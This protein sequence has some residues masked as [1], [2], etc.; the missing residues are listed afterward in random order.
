VTATGTH[1]G[2]H[3]YSFGAAA[4]QASCGIVLDVCHTAMK[5]GDTSCKEASIVVARVNSTFFQIQ[6]SLVMGGALSSR[7]PLGGVNLYFSGNFYVTGSTIHDIGLWANQAVLAAGV[8]NAT[9]QGSLGALVEFGLCPDTV[10]HA[11]VSIS[12]VSAA[13]A[14]ENLAAGPVFPS[15]DAA[16]ASA[17]AVWIKQLGAVSISQDEDRDSSTKFYSMLY[18]A[19]RAPSRLSEA[20]GIYLGMDGQ[21]HK[22][23]EDAGDVRQFHYSDMSL[24]DI[25]RTQLPLLSLVQPDVF[26]DV[27]RSLQDM[28]RTGGDIPRWPLAN[29]YTGCMI[30]SHGFASIAEAVLKG[31]TGFNVSTLYAAMYRQATQPTAHAGRSHVDDYLKFGSLFALSYLS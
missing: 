1:T 16:V 27:I 26:N 21:V 7:A 20:G 17:R 15:F 14:R 30:G 3:Q 23:G 6:A 13:Q 18:Q 10:V 22:L 11:D 25:H 4:A 24:W 12:F 28:A 5:D 29:V 31:H 9:G 8:L 19:F 2:K